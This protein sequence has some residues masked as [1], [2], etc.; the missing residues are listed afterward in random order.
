LRLRG[1][2]QAVSGVQSAQA[3]GTELARL[4]RFWPETGYSGG[5]G[6]EAGGKSLTEILKHTPLSADLPAVP[7]TLR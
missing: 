5:K 2:A 1:D 3:M 4:A 7:R 6:R